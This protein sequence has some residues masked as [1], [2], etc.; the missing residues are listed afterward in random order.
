MRALQLA[1]R[2]GPRLV[3]QESSTGRRGGGTHAREGSY[4]GFSS[5][6]QAGSA[7]GFEGRV[8]G[9]LAHARKTFEGEDG[10]DIEAG[11]GTDG[12]TQGGGSQGWASSTG[13][14]SF[15]SRKFD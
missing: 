2:M 15:N 14:G 13:G 11:D 6:N 3:S 10:E 4:G 1:G 5:Y 12:F 8:S 9:G 7:V